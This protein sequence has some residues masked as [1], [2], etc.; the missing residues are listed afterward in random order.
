M[1]LSAGLEESLTFT[2]KLDVPAFVGLPEMTPALESTSPAGRLPLEIDHLYGDFPPL[3]V[4]VA[5]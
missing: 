5:A 3:A 1:T 2:V 4:R